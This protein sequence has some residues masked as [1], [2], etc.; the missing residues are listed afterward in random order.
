MKTIK[1]LALT[2]L[3]ISSTIS[4]KKYEEPTISLRTK[5]ARVDGDWEV[6][7]CTS[8]STNFL[9]QS[10]QDTYSSPYCSSPINYTATLQV[11]DWKWSFN[12]KGTFHYSFTYTG[13]TINET[14]SDLKCTPEYQSENGSMSG[15]GTWEFNGDKTKLILNY[16][17]NSQLFSTSNTETYEIKV[18]RDKEMRLHGTIDGEK[19]YITLIQ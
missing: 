7:K 17:T 15:H 14:A 8:G 2:A 3:I 11:H 13:N 4:C 6:K 10:Y 16:G 9:N 18:L 12:K 1:L 5:K 19:V